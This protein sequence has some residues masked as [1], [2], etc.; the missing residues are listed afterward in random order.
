MW[1]KLKEEEVEDYSFDFLLRVISFTFNM[2]LLLFANKIEIMSILN[3]YQIFL[4]L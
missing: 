3:M 4:N 2:V 1:N